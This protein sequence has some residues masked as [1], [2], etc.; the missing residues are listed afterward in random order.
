NLAAENSLPPMAPPTLPK[1]NISSQQNST[2]LPPVFTP[3]SVGQSP[4]SFL[5][6][7][8]TSLRE[9]SVCLNAVKKFLS[10]HGSE[11]RGLGDRLD[12]VER[13]VSFS[14]PRDQDL[15][16]K[17]DVIEARII[18]VESKLDQHHRALSGGPGLGRK[19][20][21]DSETGS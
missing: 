8:P 15:V 7:E 13:P 12:A 3:S 17:V 10:S 16:D 6:K 20:Y 21:S 11:L 9:V 19:R 4:P 1:Q 5:T 2:P 14:Q 18:E